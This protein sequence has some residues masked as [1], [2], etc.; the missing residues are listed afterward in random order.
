MLYSAFEKVPTADISVTFVV[1]QKPKKLFSHLKAE[2]GFTIEEAYPGIYYIGGDAFPV[3]VIENNLAMG[4]TTVQ[5]IIGRYV[6]TDN[7]PSHVEVK[8]RGEE[9]ENAKRE[10]ALEMLKRGFSTEEVADIIRKPL[11]WV[12]SLMNQSNLSA[13]S[14]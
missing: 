3:Q 12:Q 6:T 4:G 7:I 2:R 9:K 10:T 11:E 1:T 14:Q 8:I 5:E 13:N